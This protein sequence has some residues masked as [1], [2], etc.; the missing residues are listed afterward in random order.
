MNNKNDINVMD[1]HPCESMLGELLYCEKV[2]GKSFVAKLIGI[3]DGFLIF[4][5]RS[6]EIIMNR[7]DSLRLIS[8]HRERRHNLAQEA[9]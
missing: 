3:K 1:S 5:N 6:G 4:E 8:E 2:T 7:M 9:A